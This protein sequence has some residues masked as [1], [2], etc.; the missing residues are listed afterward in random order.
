[1][2]A[3]V[4]LARILPLIAPYAPGVSELAASYNA[5]LAAIELCEKTLCWRQIV[6]VEMTEDGQEIGLPDGVAIHQFETAR[7]GE[8]PLT[9]M[10]FSDVDERAAAASYG[11]PP[12]FI[13]QASYNTV[14]LIPF[15]EGTLSL[16]VFVKPITENAY[17]LNAA[18]E[19]EDTYDRVPDWMIQQHAET[20]AAGA[21]ARL[22]IQPDRP[23]TNADLGMFYAQKFREA[24]DTHFSVNLTGQH[25]ARRRTRFNDF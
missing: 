16:S 3:L 17:G 11:A 9:P 10:Q 21:L 2:A 5:R 23:Y 24:A 8:L 25:R 22:L 18:G 7:H 1:M 12:Q 4:N 19:I 14:R 13:T 15:M 20:L 6:T